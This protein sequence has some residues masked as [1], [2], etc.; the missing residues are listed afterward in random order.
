MF[1]TDGCSLELMKCDITKLEV[2]AIV[3]AANSAASVSVGTT[4]CPSHL[5]RSRPCTTNTSV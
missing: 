2:D 4:P 5:F 3:N 1:R